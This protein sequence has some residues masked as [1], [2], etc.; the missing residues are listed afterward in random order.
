MSMVTTCPH[1]HTTFRVRHEDLQS[2]QGRVRC[3]QC[4]EIFNAF[5]SLATLDEAPDD[6]AVQETV[7]QVRSAPQKANA[8]P[9]IPSLQTKVSGKKSKPLKFTDEALEKAQQNRARTIAWSGAAL[10]LLALL[11]AQVAYFLR[12]PVAAYY[13]QTKP[14]LQR[15]CQLLECTVDLPRYADWVSIEASDLQ[16]DPQ[17]PNLIILTATLRNRAPFAQA[18]PALELTFTN[19]QDQMVARRVFTPAHYLASSAN[20][21]RGMD[22]NN[23][24]T[25]KLYIDSG[26]LKPSGYRLFLFYQ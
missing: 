20:A 19:T 14:Y 13:P 16:A 17:R 9:S 23:E 6:L 7:L 18:Y 5:E 25:A 3:G 2:S 15:F 12:V 4:I 26:D 1:C 8:V 10:L 21:G 24:F 11:S 22:A